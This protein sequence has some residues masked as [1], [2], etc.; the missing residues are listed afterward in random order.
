MDLFV[1]EKP[2]IFYYIPDDLPEPIYGKEDFIKSVPDR[3]VKLLKLTNGRSLVLFT[4]YESLDYTYQEV[5][6]SLSEVIV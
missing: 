3:V 1:K 6:K 2:I 4:S 5:L